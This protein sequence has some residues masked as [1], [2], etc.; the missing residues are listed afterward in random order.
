MYRE[1]EQGSLV[2]VLR[3]YTVDGQAALWL[4]YPKANVLTAKVRVFIDFLR[5]RLGGLPALGSATRPPGRS[6]RS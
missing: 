3:D 4:V 1:L 6:S 5:D 2:Q